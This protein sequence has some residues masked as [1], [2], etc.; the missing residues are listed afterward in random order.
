MEDRSERLNSEQHVRSAHRAPCDPSV[1]FQGSRELPLGLARAAVG[2]CLLAIMAQ[3]LPARAQ[4]QLPLGQ[5]AARPGRPALPASR[6][7]RLP[8]RPTAQLRRMAVLAQSSK[9]ELSPALASGP[10]GDNG[11]GGRGGGG[12]GNGDGGSGGAGDAT[13]PAGMLLAG[14]AIESLPAGGVPGGSGGAAGPLQ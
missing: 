9:D 8:L 4:Q 13:A 1:G 10:P 7:L 3:L 14:K 2:V 6:A 11:A 12:D 5:Q